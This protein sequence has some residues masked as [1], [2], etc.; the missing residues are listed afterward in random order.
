MTRPT[1]M[2]VLRSLLSGCVTS[3][4]HYSQTA[5]R[6]V[7]AP[8]PQPAAVRSSKVQDRAAAPM[9]LGAAY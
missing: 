3:N 8:R 5:V 7:A 9:M 4:D 6:S 2:L 1:L